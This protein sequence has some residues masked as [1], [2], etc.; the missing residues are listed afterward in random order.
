MS[1]VRLP[2]VTATVVAEAAEADPN[3]LLTAANV[4]LGVIVGVEG[5]VTAPLTTKAL[6]PLS[7]YQVPELPDGLIRNLTIWPAGIFWR[8]A[9]FVREMLYELPVPEVLEVL[10]VPTFVYAPPFT[11]TSTKAVVGPELDLRVKPVMLVTDTE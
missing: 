9:T 7:I 2:P 10:I 4:P 6:A 1:A 5:A 3:V 11:D 8:E